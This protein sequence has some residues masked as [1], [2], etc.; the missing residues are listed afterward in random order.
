M[1]NADA[2]KKLFEGLYASELWAM[3]E[4]EF[5]CWVN[6]DYTG[7]VNDITPRLITKA[8]FIDNPNVDQDGCLPA[9]VEYRRDG[10]WAEY[11]EDDPD[12]WGIVRDDKNLEAEGYRCWTSKPSLEQREATPWQ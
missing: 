1:T 11:W 8:D 4:D 9:W 3:P 10:D 12:Y 2:F 7:E 6:G 5:L